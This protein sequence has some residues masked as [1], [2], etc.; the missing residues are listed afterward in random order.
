M[1]I[2][3]KFL[4]LLCMFTLILVILAACGGSDET[5]TTDNKESDTS[6]NADEAPSDEPVKVTMMANLHTPETPNDKVLNMIEEATNSELEI[7]WVPD[8]TYQDR[9]NTAFATGSLPQVVPMGFNMFVQFKEA[10]R[11]DQFWEIGPYLEEFENLNKLKPEILENTMVDGKIYSLYQGRPLSRQGFIYRKDWADNLGLETP[12]NTEEFYEMVRAFSEDDPDGNG[13]N[14]TIGLT[15]RSDLVYGGFKTIASWFGTPN[16]WGIKDGELQPEFMFDE[17]MQTLDYLKDIHSNGY[18]NQDF[19]VTSKPDQQAMIKNGTAGVYVGS[20]PDVQSL[21][22]D[23]VELNPDLEYDV[24]NYIEGPDGEYGTWAIPGYGSVFLFPKSAIATE[25]ELKAILG[26]FDKF[27]TT[28]VANLTV[29]GVEGEHYEVIDGRAAALED[30]RTAIDN[31]VRPLMSLEIG[32]PETSGRYDAYSHYEVKAKA[33]E[34]VVENNDY[35]IH[36]PTV[37]LDS[38][39]YVKNSETLSQIMVDATYKYILGQIDKDGFN[40][41]IES[42]KSQGG[43]EV[44]AE[45]NAHYNE[46]N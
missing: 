4:S 39:T 18:M 46:I 31:E 40:A 43:S 27:M 32:E 38:E 5:T 19:P 35:L 20:M 8:S 21:Y 34:L 33:D 12:T 13:K 24:A 30:N 41:A 7:Q 26:V 14:D 45:F 37:T 1:K 22:N 3:K 23:A 28:E 36:N 16:E 9:L 6:N 29:W 44:M 15:D 2:S 42:W 25:E 11:D 10:I 17:Y